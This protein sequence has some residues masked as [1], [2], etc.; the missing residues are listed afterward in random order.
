[1]ILNDH[2]R[3]LR[4]GIRALG[5]GIRSKRHIGMHA[6]GTVHIHDFRILELLYDLGKSARAPAPTKSRVVDI[7]KALST[8]HHADIKVPLGPLSFDRM[9]VTPLW[10]PCFPIDYPLHVGAGVTC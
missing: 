5:V 4:H 9:P 3:A 1:M 8:D 10:L 7:P 6:F 2:K